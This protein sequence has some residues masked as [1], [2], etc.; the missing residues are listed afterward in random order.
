VWATTK[1]WYPDEFPRLREYAT[2]VLGAKR[3]VLR[4]TWGP[5]KGAAARW[6]EEV[7]ARANAKN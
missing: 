3:F 2:G 4:D 5:S 1:G 6:E 7:A